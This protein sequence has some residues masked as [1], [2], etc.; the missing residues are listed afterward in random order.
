M[1]TQIVQLLFG[2]LVLPATAFMIIASG[3]FLLRRCASETQSRI[4]P[5]VWLFPVLCLTGLVIAYPMVASIIYAFK[6]ATASSWV[7]FSN[8]SWAFGRALRTVLFNNALWIIIFPLVT[9]SLALLAAI[10]MDRVKYEKIARTFLI[11]PTAISFVAGA[12]IWKMIYVYAPP[13]MPQTGTANALM[14][15]FGQ[16][17][18]AWL[19]D[20]SLNNFALIGVAVWMSMG[21][22]TLILSAGV[23][24]IPSD[25]S[26]AAR[27]DGAGELAIFRYVTL[28]SLWPTILVVLTTEAI[29]SLKVFDII[30]VMTNGAFGTD[31]IAN[32]MYSELFVKENLGTASAIAV[33]LLIMASPVIIMNVR[34][35]RREA[36]G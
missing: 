23:K 20:R 17:P 11:L 26:E 22:A 33:L 27:I 15:L 24:A 34:Q 9:C 18:V 21:V 14:S 7:G 31:V 16:A 29:F 36:R 3:E 10:L 32:R 30:Y 2:I 28:P 8:F 6:D 13:S 25:L 19:M 4:R 1:T 12:V 5:W 35:M